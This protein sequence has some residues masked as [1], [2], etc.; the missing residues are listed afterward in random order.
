M[1]YYVCI[2]KPKQINLEGINKM[3]KKQKN[4]TAKKI[5]KPYHLWAVEIHLTDQAKL[6]GILPAEYSLVTEGKTDITKVRRHNDKCTVCKR[7]KFEFFTK[8]PIANGNDVKVIGCE[9]C[10]KFITLYLNERTHGNTT[11]HAYQIAQ[12][13]TEYLGRACACGYR[14]LITAKINQQQVDEQAKHDC[15]EW[16]RNKRRVS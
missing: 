3:S 13:V 11:V 2:D 5:A 15:N 9:Y 6:K 7:Y 14:P 8:T 4:K 16:R 12:G 1:R 10:E